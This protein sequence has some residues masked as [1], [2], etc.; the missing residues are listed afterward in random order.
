RGGFTVLVDFG[1]PPEFLTTAQ[2]ILKGIPFDYVVLRPSLRICAERRIGRDQGK[3]EDYG[4]YEDLYDRFKT[5]SP[6]ISEDGASIE[7]CVELVKNGLQS[8]TFAYHR[9]KVASS[10][11][12]RFGGKTHQGP[13]RARSSDDLET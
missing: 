11:T 9:S 4:S 2:A 1:V 5:F 3:I 8:R 12:P 6:A 7:R 10:A 13:V